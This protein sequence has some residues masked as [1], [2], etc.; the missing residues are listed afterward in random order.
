M[1]SL[2]GFIGDAIDFVGDIFGSTDLSGQ[3]ITA[4]IQTAGEFLI[5]G[6]GQQQ[7]SSQSQPVSKVHGGVATGR[8]PRP[9][10]PDAA[11][12]ADPATFYA[13]W[14]ARMSKFTTLAATT[15]TG[16][17]RTLGTQARRT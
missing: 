10:T 8:A 12:V 3:L 13:E 6:S 5:G 14:I 4:G 17:P 7:G 9:N 15:S 2:F 1:G 16:G 11:G